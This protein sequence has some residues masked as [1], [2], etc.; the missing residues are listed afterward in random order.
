MIKILIVDDELLVRIG[1]KST[2]DWEKYGFTLVGEAKNAKEAEELFHKFSP[3]ILLTDISMPGIN[4]LE[5]ISQL[6]NKK[7]ELQSII[8]THYEDFCYAREALQL[9][10]LDY[11]LKSNLTPE[12]LLAVLQKAE[13][14]LPGNRENNISGISTSDGKNRH[15]RSELLLSYFEEVIKYKKTPANR[16]YDQIDGYA[17]YQLASISIN[18]SINDKL[19]LD[20]REIKVIE[21]VSSQILSSFAQDIQCLIHENRI[22][23][24]FC[25][26]KILSKTEQ[27]MI[28]IKLLNSVVTNLKKI[29]NYYMLSGISLASDTIRSLGNMY[30]QAYAAGQKSFFDDSHLTLY[31]PESDN[32]ATVHV[33]VDLVKVKALLQEK[34]CTELE[35]YFDELFSV[36]KKLRD[37]P[38][39]QAIYNQILELFSLYLKENNNGEQYSQLSSSMF[40]IENFEKLYDFN[41][42]KMHILNI[43]TLLMGIDNKED[44]IQ[45]SHIIKK[46]IS[47]I[48]KNYNQNISLSNLA[49]NVEV[50]RNYLSFLFKQEL[51]L[52][53]SHYLTGIRIDK[54]KRMLAVTNMKIYEIADRV[55]FDS[56]YYFSKVFKETTG[57]TCSEYRNHYYAH[58]AP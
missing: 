5:L 47:F 12:R 35:I 4:G 22:N 49:T 8:L 33:T 17:S 10:A 34:K 52:N 38:L 43:V 45:M 16:L 37:K 23:Y 3:D 20:A 58:D 42:V 19:N 30:E 29:L 25:F 11:I 39:F 46:S 27:D 2:L 56:P 31:E 40:E 9:G 55:G 36:L 1:L 41:A 14:Q 54:A 7:P 6:K 48:E 53:F 15:N 44:N 26:K 51:G 57:M 28:I 24:L 18:L 21:E 32:S 50:S 13:S